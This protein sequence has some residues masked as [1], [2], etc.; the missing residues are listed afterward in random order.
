MRFGIGE[1]LRKAVHVV[2]VL[3]IPVLYQFGAG[4]TSALFFSIALGLYIYPGIVEAADKTPIGR[5]LRAFQIA[6][7]FLERKG[8]RRYTGAI[9]FFGSIGVI[10]LIFPVKI[11]AVSIIVLSIGDGVSTLAGLSMGKNRLFHNESKSWEG[12][13]SGFA[14]S[15]IFCLTITSLPAAVFASFVGM[16]VE[17]FETKINDNLSVPFAVAISLYAASYAGFLAV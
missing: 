14:A 8:Q 13:L 16:V 15:T 6:F 12:S 3:A 5:I 2:G 4:K 10:V 17:S 11:A 1:L 9:Y 7:D